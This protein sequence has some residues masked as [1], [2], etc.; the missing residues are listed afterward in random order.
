MG[1]LKRSKELMEAM[2][3]QEELAGAMKIKEAES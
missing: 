3:R 1:A 2:M